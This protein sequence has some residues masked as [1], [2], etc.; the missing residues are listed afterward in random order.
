MNISDKIKEIEAELKSI[1]GEKERL[2]VKE[3]L[4]K[5]SLKQ[6]YIMDNKAKEIESALK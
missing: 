6:F 5:K 4:L 3:K 1:E 2:T